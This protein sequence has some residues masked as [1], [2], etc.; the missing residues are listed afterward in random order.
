MSF[1][2]DWSLLADSHT[3]ADSFIHKLNNALSSASRPSFLGPI[4]VTEFD[5]GTVGPD[6]EIKDIGDVWKSF[7]EDD[8][9][10]DSQDGNGVGVNRKPEHN[11]GPDGPIASAEPSVYAYGHYGDESCSRS[12]RHDERYDAMAG[13]S[14][15]G[16]QDLRQQKN[17]RRASIQQH[18]MLNDDDETG[19]VFSGML[20]PRVSL[21][22]FGAGIGLGSGMGVKLDRRPR[23][24]TRAF[25][26]HHAGAESVG[27]LD[28]PLAYPRH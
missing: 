8:E 16:S 7:I 25:G 23:Q 22:R 4:Q 18:V 28:A 26:L 5:F 11:T 9:E 20:S 13:R 19:S 1:E 10:A 6:I 24:W 17:G 21:H 27:L 3:L 12:G 2:I 14:R 15:R